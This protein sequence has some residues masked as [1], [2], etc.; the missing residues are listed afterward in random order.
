MT[1]FRDIFPPRRSLRFHFAAWSRARQRRALLLRR[2]RP[3]LPTVDVNATASTAASSVLRPQL[4][5]LTISPTRPARPFRTCWRTVPGIQLQSLF[6]GV[7]GVDTSVDLRGFGAF[8]TAN[9]LILINGRR[10]Q[11][12]RSCGRRPLN[13]SAAIDRTHRNHQRQQRRGAV[14]RQCHRWRYQ[15]HYENRGQRRQADCRCA[16]RAASDRSISNKA[17]PHSRRITGPGRLPLFG[18][19]VKSDGYRVNNALDQRNAAGEIRYTTIGFQRILQSV[20]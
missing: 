4:S 6:G 3:P 11:R 1:L 12:S 15:H 17:L 9:T 8:A 19:V 5:R 7:N 10:R 14:R 20:R 13:D 16:S 18:N 2:T